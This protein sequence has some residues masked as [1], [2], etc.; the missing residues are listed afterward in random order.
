MYIDNENFPLTISIRRNEEFFA[1]VDWFL[2]TKF[3]KKRTKPC[4]QKVNHLYC[5]QPTDSI[6]CYLSDDRKEVICKCC[7]TTHILSSDPLNLD[8]NGWWNEEGKGEF[9]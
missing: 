4:G 6:H 8:E 1:K 3:G 9:F 2:Y 5:A 7:G